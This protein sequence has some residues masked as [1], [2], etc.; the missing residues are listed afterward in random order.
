MNSESIS[1]H[2]IPN[3]AAR[4]VGGTGGARWA[5]T[6]SRTVGS[7]APDIALLTLFLAGGVTSVGATRSASSGTT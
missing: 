2:P 7:Q 5:L 6:A 4:P 1:H 3:L